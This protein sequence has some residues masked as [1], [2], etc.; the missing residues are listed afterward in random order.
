M[1]PSR[2]EVL[3]WLQGWLG[4]DLT[5]AG[6]SDVL[7]ASGRDGAEANALVVAFAERFGVD[8]TGYRL[9]MHARSNGQAL[10]PGWPILVPPPHGAMVPLSVSL[11]HAAAVTHRWPV[12][13]PVLPEVR[14]LSVVN[15][16]V[17]AAGLIGMTL[18]VLWAVPRLF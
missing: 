4:Q 14:D 6:Q 5:P 18:L 15:L 3:E 1:T 11:L 16:P 7:A 13:Y 17:L 8:M 9:R 12:T 2:I 10:R